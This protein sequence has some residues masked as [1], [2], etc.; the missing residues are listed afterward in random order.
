MNTRQRKIR[1]HLFAGARELA[2]QD[3]VDLELAAEATVADLRQE[4]ESTC[5]SLSPLL[6]H[7]L[8]AINAS[9]AGDDA[10][11]PRGADIACIPPVSGG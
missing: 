5:P 11:L 2:G 7:A 6:S 1:V 10:I 8:F 4:L 3:W 9:Y